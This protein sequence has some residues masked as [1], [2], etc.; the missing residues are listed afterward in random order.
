MIPALSGF[1]DL[2]AAKAPGADS[3]P[4]GG[5]TDF[6]SNRAKVHIPT[7]TAHI[8]SVADGVSELRPLAADV[9]N[10]CHEYSEGLLELSD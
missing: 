10:L 8:V 4:F 2:A 7:P 9:T 3:D 1:D 6:G 5:C